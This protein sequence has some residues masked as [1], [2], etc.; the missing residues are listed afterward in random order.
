[1]ISDS[2]GTS[3]AGI[4]LGGLMAWR[5]LAAGK[6]FQALICLICIG[7]LFCLLILEL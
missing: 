2:I 6:R 3:F 1:M 4:L 5:R 7:V